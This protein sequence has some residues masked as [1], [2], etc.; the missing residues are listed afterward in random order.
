VPVIIPQTGRVDQAFWIAAQRLQVQYLRQ[1]VSGGHA[2]PVHDWTRVESGI[3]HDFHVAWIPEL[4]KA[5]NGGLLPEGYY[6]LAEQHAGRAITDVLTL[7][8]SPAPPEPPFPPPPATGGLAVAEAPPRARLRQTIESAA[9]ARR[10]SLA[11]RHV[12]G[13]RLVALLEIVSPANKDRAEHVE[14]L[15]VKVTSA[16][17]LGIHVVIVDLLPPG[18]HDP[19]GMHGAILRRL[20]D[21]AEGYRVPAGERLT[22]ASYAAGPTIEIYV[23]HVGVGAGLPEVPLFLRPDRYVN[24]PLEATY[25]EAYA[26]MP[27]FWRDV[28]EGQTPV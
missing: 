13:H 7:H 16:L 3:F 15:A 28:L 10:R 8:A 27:L 5:L 20:D 1:C 18:P 23:E 26:G 2:M 6:A 4:R 12:S 11:I 22:L 24:L 14:E 9:L 25:Q 19:G 21:S 17:D